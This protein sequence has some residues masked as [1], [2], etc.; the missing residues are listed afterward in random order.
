[1]T[2]ATKKRATQIV[3]TALL[4][5]AA[6]AAGWWL[7]TR[8]NGPAALSGAPAGPGLA[9]AQA[10]GTP[11]PFAVL[12]CSARLFENAPA[13][14][15]TFTQPL[16][17]G[18]DLAR[19][20]RVKDLGAVA[21]SDKRSSGQDA[22]TDTG[23][24]QPSHAAPAKAD[25]A[26][27]TPVE[28]AWV[29][30][31][32]PRV[33]YFPYVK[34]L[35]RYAV[36]ADAQLRAAD[37][38][39]LPSAASCEVASQAM[40]PAFYFASRG[41]VLPAGQNGGLPVVT[42][43]VPEVDVEFLRIEPARIPQFYDNILGIRRNSDSDDE[44][45]WRD[46][47]SRA[48]Q[49]SVG[50]WDLDRL[51]KLSQSVFRGRFLAGAQADRRHLTFLPVEDIE[52][53]QQ[54]GIYIAVMSEPGRFRYEYQVSY[55]YVSDIGLHTRRHPEHID[56]FAT[57]LKSAQAMSDV[58][59][60]LL[61][62]QGKSLAS[63]PADSQGHAHF[64]GAFESARLLL[65]KRG[66]EQ[67]LVALQQ[68]ALDLSEF[69]A[70]GYPSR[71]NR[72]FAYA[73][74]DLYRPGET[75]DLSVLLRG[76]DGAL[77]SAPAPL[78]ATLKR[79]DGRIVRTELWQTDPGIPGYVRHA[80]ALPPD[81]PTGT[82]L[83]ELRMD[84]AAPVADTTWRFQVEEFLPERMKLQL[85][86]SAPLLLPNEAL[87]VS[88]QG[89]YLFGAPAAG[90]RLLGTLLIERKRIALP[91]QW[92]GFIF[93][94]VADDE[95]RQW[96]ELPEQEL[97]D[98]GAASVEI[99]LEL[100]TTHSPMQV[101]ASFSLLESGGRP[102]VRSTEATVWPANA[103]IGV[104]PL[105]ANDVTREGAL[106]EFEVAR[107][108][109]GGALLPLKSAQMR[110][111]REER[112]YYWRFD[113]QS[114]WNSGF[115]E[116]EELVE[117]RMLDL[118]ARTKLSLPVQWG[119]YRLEITDTQLN[120]TL[121]YRFYA[122][123][124]A[125]D[126][127]AMGNRPD[128]VQLKL[129]KEPVRAG[130]TIAV[131]MT[132]PHDGDAIVTVEADRVLW[133]Q[134]VAAKAS[135]TTVRIA[136]DPAWQRHD[137]YVSAV[138]FRPGAQGDVR[139]TPARAVGLI[140]VPLDRAERK[141]ALS[142][143]ASAKA[144][145]ETRSQVT[146]K[147]DPPPANGQ[148]WATLSA[149]DVGIL[150][151]TRFATPN[152]FDF[153]FGQQRYGAEMLDMYG[154]LIEK[155]QGVR[156]RL[157]WGGDAAQRDTNTLPSR[158]QLTDLFSGPVQFDASGQ[159]VVTLDLP[160][161]NGTLRL[162]ATAFTDNAFGSS[163][164]EM[165]VAAPIVAEL[166][167]P[168]FITPG[169]ATTLALDLT[170]LSGSQQDMTVTL[171]AEHPAIIEDV[172]RSLTLADGER[173]TLRFTASTT[174]SFGEALV[175]LNVDAGKGPDAIRISRKSV[176]A[177]QPAAAAQRETQRLRLAPGASFQLP[178][179]RLAAYFADSVTVGITASGTPPFNL[180][181]LARDLLDYPYGCTEQTASAA[182]PL[183]LIDSQLAASA[184]LTG[185][186]PE[187]RRSR[188]DSA[189]ARLT[190]MQKSTGGFSL[191]TDG[192]QDVWLT[193]YVTGF[194]Q[195]ARSAGYA[196]PD[197]ML[198][199]AHEW[200][201][202]RL[203]ETPDRFPKLPG[204]LAVHQRGA[205]Y[206]DAD[207][208]LLRDSHQRF[209]GLAYAGYVLAREQKAPLA[210]LRQLHEFADRSRSPLPLVQLA[211][212]LRLMG[213]EPRALQA[214][215][216]A[217]TRP[218]GIDA[219][220]DTYGEWL[221]DYGSALRDNAMSYVL[222]Q[223]HQLQHARH[224]VL[225]TEVSAQLNG[226]RWLST[227]EQLALLMAATAAGGS[228]DAP[229]AMTVAQ[230]GTSRG[231][232]SGAVQSLTLTGA[233]KGNITLTN[234]SAAPVFVELDI[235]GFAIATPT[236][237]SHGANI[238]RR[239]YT[240]DGAPW[241]GGELHTG[242]TLIVGLTASADQAIQN[243]LIVDRVPAGFEIDNLNLSQG[244]GLQDLE[245]DGVRVGEAMNDG[246]IAHR[247]YRDDR[248][249]AAVRI[250][251]PVTVFYRVQVVNPG[252]YNV[253]AAVVEDMYRPEI[254]GV[255]ASQP[256]LVITDPRAR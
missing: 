95:R 107:V 24:S 253:P 40:P 227:Q 23:D 136:L 203:R 251:S 141:L 53:L 97:D 232:A 154:K 256:A 130:D 91:Q 220:R 62:D 241:A 61:D 17:T 213:D 214:L 15:V 248:Y 150:N 36:A 188:I 2:K 143:Q 22:D 7:G 242:D 206:S 74:R 160:D 94:D 163:E 46:N 190:G 83:L 118:D 108:T 131:H 96:Q 21:P 57:S 173:R 134:R 109:S 71:N 43:N 76:P 111:Y 79:P 1:M 82:W 195:D 90:N 145:P 158:V 209:A 54:P 200:L 149:V 221:G 205:A 64:A 193:A 166:S 37:D 210:S 25:S 167:K 183:L 13:L 194:L 48:M 250:D 63:A 152:A 146:L 35:R 100:G 208:A 181:Q 77:M 225:L 42:V 240:P 168:R 155:M 29:V 105:F 44:D 102:V 115:V 204:K 110:L 235:R 8:D 123:W 147:L 41:V 252:R 144:L 197:A 239:W 211:A 162:M 186:S 135:G 103:L 231:L 184:G 27:G 189:I 223:R 120:Q 139:V 60:E 185:L 170:N 171:R 148:A 176:L 121:R 114:G 199:R 254:R 191:W 52:A 86:P 218:Y 92:P 78:T 70:G 202:E 175:T 47:S 142:L 180:G 201:L 10:S 138:V 19:L 140:H 51:N 255:G 45:E 244:S 4:V 182:Y 49:G 122:G 26:A 127:E 178:A 224:E 56:A 226:R 67:T 72:L 229:W 137:L 33:A 129:D 161:F 187:Q 165:V 228:Q 104:R 55:F 50:L 234:T 215:E 12:E 73:G 34:P 98:S 126:A 164:R 207:Y 177:V 18:Q 87:R 89:D 84:P 9:S 38:S 66:N 236:A 112:E 59:F 106:A 192:A 3:A 153:F 157:K 117:S 247:E 68:P 217:M 58:S 233:D 80:V 113:D 132:P 216:A 39:A 16:A 116:T 69:D 75:Y 11:D 249:V 119:R 93:G 151:I 32:N 179:E 245:L 6:V 125:Q 230:A 237:A 81:A 169:D 196:V 128:R 30:G 212:A 172:K 31:D 159:A 222:M 28:G 219:A 88:A 20:L 65:A 246:R 238:Q 101:K 85:T 156:G 133:S 14:A 174:G 124:N 198:K 243:A 5:G 99:P